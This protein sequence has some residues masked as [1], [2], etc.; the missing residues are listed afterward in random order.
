[1]TF[2]YLT[3]CS[4]GEKRMENKHIGLLSTL[5]W[6]VWISYCFVVYPLS[7]SVSLDCIKCITTNS[8]LT[9]LIS[10]SQFLFTFQDFEYYKYWCLEIFEALLTVIRNF[11]S[12]Q[13]LPNYCDQI[14]LNYVIPDISRWQWRS[15]QFTEPVSHSRRFRSTWH[16]ISSRLLCRQH[17]C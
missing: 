14:L 15:V 17:P 3:W 2:T 7:N 9:Y 1:M 10:F 4:V 5:S 16:Q 11:A 8:T 13:W 12:L 6:L